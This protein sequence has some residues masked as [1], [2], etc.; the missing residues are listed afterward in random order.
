M[1]V[2]FS[3]LAAIFA[4]FVIVLSKAGISSDMDPTL[5]FGVEVLC[6][7]VITWSVILSK[8]MQKKLFDVDRKVWIFIIAAGILTT[9]SSLA[10][11]HSLKIGVASRTSSFEKVSLVFSVLLSIIFLKDKFNWQ[12]LTGVLLMVAG[13]LFIAFSNTSK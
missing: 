10:S 6:M 8:N 13:S 7:L 12:I 5:V 3:L 9:F 1:W 4:A 2:L 11:F